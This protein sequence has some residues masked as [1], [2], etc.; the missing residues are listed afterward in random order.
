MRIIHVHLLMSTDAE[1]S[2]PIDV[3]LSSD[4]I[5]IPYAAQPVAKP[6]PALNSRGKTHRN[7]SMETATHACMQVTGASSRHTRMH[8]RFSNPA[9]ADVQVPAQ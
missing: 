4:G 2:S 8:I 5:R 6:P 3:V 7:L 1:Y 9:L